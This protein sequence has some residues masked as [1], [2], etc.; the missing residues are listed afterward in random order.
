MGN[1]CVR[2]SS[3]AN[4]VHSPDRANSSSGDNNGITPDQLINARHELSEV[5]GL[6]RE[7]HSFISSNSAPADLRDRHNTLFRNTQTVLDAVDIHDRS[8]RGDISAISSTTSDQ[9]MSSIQSLKS[10]W[11]GFRRELQQAMPARASSE[12]YRIAEQPG[13][14]MQ[15]SSLTPSPYRN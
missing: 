4:Q 11:D 5:A 3:M 14:S 2:G 13:G 10:K 7:V 12:H 8:V 15:L 1:M 6:P 9:L